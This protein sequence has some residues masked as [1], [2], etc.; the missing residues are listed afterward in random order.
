MKLGGQLVCEVFAVI[1]VAALVACLTGCEVSHT[2]TMKRLPKAAD[3][4][5]WCDTA[6][7]KEKLRHADQC[8]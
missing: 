7:A 6:T 5:E 4:P 8:L 3:A 1:A 2:V